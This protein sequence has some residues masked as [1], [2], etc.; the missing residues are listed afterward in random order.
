MQKHRLNIGS[1]IIPEGW[2]VGPS[3][4]LTDSFEAKT[5]WVYLPPKKY[6]ASYL[7][8]RSCSAFL[9]PSLSLKRRLF[10]S[11][12]RDDELSLKGPIFD[13]RHNSPENWSHFINVKMSL[14]AILCRE[15]EL[16]WREVTLILPKSFPE[17]IKAL[18]RLLEL[19]CVYTD[20]LV[21]G[22]GYEI[23]FPRPSMIRG[24][25]EEIAR[26]I[27]NNP[28]AAAIHGGKIQRSTD[29]P[30]RILLLRRGPRSLTNLTEV[31]EVLRK[32]GFVTIFPEDLT[33]DQKLRVIVD[34]K[35]IIGIHGAGLAPISF[36][37][38][39]S[40]PLRLIELT[41]IGHLRD[42]FRCMSSNIEGK[43]CCVRGY[44]EKDQYSQMYRR[45]YQYHRD[46]KRSFRVDPIAVVEALDFL[47]S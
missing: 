37:G 42:L 14:L 45:P 33:V 30:D 7:E 11:I 22:P 5:E 36:R 21:N 19:N 8:I 29:S 20:A 35:E 10:R 27:H 26:D 28:V 43:W 44:V 6:E 9:G 17:Y 31:E 41:P 32:E 16:S 4:F 25:R 2:L 12:E 34:A 38:G 15:L 24:V 40:V 3:S 47:R 13:L 23:V 39:S 46:S 18:C 1:T